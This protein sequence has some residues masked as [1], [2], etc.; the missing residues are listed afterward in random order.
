MSS[1]D[2]PAWRLRAISD[3]DF[4]WNYGLHEAALG[5]YIAALWGWD[6]E[7]QRRMFTDA[8]HRQDRQVIVVGADDVG[9]LA[10]EERPDELWLELLE[11]LP[12]WQGKGIGAAVLRWL[13]EHAA[14]SGRTLSLHVLTTNPRARAFYTREGLRVVA[15]GP[16]RLLMRSSC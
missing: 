12:A 8:F 9:V 7:L 13:L 3:A 11:L 5:E 15:S 6:E 1:T 4:E 10:V 14:D 2:V 16:S